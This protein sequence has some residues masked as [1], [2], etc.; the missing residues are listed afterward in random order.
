MDPQPRQDMARKLSSEEE[1]T[2]VQVL[3]SGEGRE[4][5]AAEDG[6]WQRLSDQQEAALVLSEELS[7]WFGEEFRAARFH[8]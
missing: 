4:L 8:R 1:R 7:E 5:E 3:Q 2:F 6:F